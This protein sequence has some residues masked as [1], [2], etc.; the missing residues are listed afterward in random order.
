[1]STEILARIQFA[2]TT[3]FHYVFP[4]LSIGL[5]LM[6]VLM[7]G[8]WMVTKNPLY[9]RMT[10]FWVRVFALIFGLGVASGIVLE[11]EF[12]TNWATY[13]RYVGDIFGSALAAEGVF[14][15]FL[16]S[17]FLAVLVFGW[18][19]VSP[20]VHFL[21]TIMVAI[22]STFSAVWI[23][24]A[25]SWMQTPA[26]YKIVGSGMDARAK[27][28]DFWAMVFNPSAMNRLSHVLSAAW[29]TGSFLVI[30]VGAY[31]LLKGRHQDFGKASM[32]FGLAVAS[33][34]IVLQVVT[35]HESAVGV[36]KNQPSKL[37]AM[38]GHWDSSKPLDIVPLGYVDAKTGETKGIHIPN[39]GSLL[40]SW[41]ATKPVKGLDQIPVEDRPPLQITFQAYHLMLAVG[42]ALAGLLAVA[43][44]MWRRGTLWTSKPMLAALVAAVVL[45][46]IGNQAGWIGA[47]V[48]RQPW[49]VYG[50]LR[51]SEALSKAVKA[52][53]IMASL[54]LFILLYALLFFLFLYMLDRQIKHGPESIGPFTDDLDPLGDYMPPSEEKV[55]EEVLA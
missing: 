42:S 22:G 49:I 39:A 19:K 54:V 15:F 8:A 4:P 38:E 40:L 7:E 20:K 5:G 51:T 21:S 55:L 33:L 47:E 3:M 14:A 11:F 26:G 30:S 52:G 36:A 32:K 29:L 9:E 53:Q 17:G 45:P 12:G 16:E 44:V 24:V 1:M 34:A 13:S 50:M 31:Y 37:A 35:G 23:V 28:T 48:G 18:D 46:Q 27:I 10:H 25:N 2:F 41:D 43:L 6:L